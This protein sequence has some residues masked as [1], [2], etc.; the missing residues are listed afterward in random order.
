MRAL[1]IAGTGM[2][3]QNTYRLAM[4]LT[5][6]IFSPDGPELATLVAI[7][8]LL[9]GRPGPRRGGGFGRNVFTS[10]VPAREAAMLATVAPCLCART[11]SSHSERR[12]HTPPLPP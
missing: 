8:L 7:H 1:Q 5:L 2:L 11:Q 12:Y 3:A 4:S 6:G 9:R 10:S